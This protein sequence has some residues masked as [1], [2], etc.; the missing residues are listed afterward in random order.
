MATSIPPAR[1]TREALAAVLT[2]GIG[3]PI[4]P[5]LVSQ[6]AAGTGYVRPTPGADYV[7]FQNG[8]FHAP[9]LNLSVVIVA[10]LADPSGALAWLDDQ[11]AKA[12]DALA[13]DPTLGGV[14]ADEAVIRRVSEPGL[15]G[16]EW[17][18]VRVELVPVEVARCE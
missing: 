13:A 15:I 3:I 14:I 11:V 1:R 12:W 18:A 2:A 6:V 17:L 9:T 8:S 10:T 5:E 16:Q 4:A 7:D